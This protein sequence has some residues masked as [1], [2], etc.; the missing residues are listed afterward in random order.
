MI[1]TQ[2]ISASLHSILSYQRKYFQ[3][4]NRYQEFF[5]HEFPSILVPELHFI[6]VFKTELKLSNGEGGGGGG[7]GGG[8]AGGGD[9][10]RGETCSGM[11]I[12]W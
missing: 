2:N 3:P 1:A 10:F 11:K 8:G 12:C 6:R 4:H 9:S 5:F 7:G